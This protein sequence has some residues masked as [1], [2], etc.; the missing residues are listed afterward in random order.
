MGRVY[1]AAGLNDRLTD[2]LAACTVVLVTIVCQPSGRPATRAGR[3]DQAPGT[4]GP[5][6]GGTP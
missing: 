6:T 1:L 5:R 4:A 2:N 3:H